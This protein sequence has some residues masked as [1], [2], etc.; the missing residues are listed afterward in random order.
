ME[1]DEI[2]NSSFFPP[3]AQA[4]KQQELFTQ[5]NLQRSSSQTFISHHVH[6]CQSYQEPNALYAHQSNFDQMRPG[7]SHP[8]NFVRADIEQVSNDPKSK[9]Y[10]RSSHSSI[11]N[12][13]ARFKHFRKMSLP[14]QYYLNG[15]LGL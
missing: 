12:I 8:Q 14:V 6:S 2:E 13:R 11:I 4:I 10:V 5:L 3:N 1:I 15:F 9:E 7:E